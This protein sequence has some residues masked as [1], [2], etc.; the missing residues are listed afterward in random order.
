[1]VKVAI[2]ILLCGLFAFASTSG[3]LTNLNPRF[4]SKQ[5]LLQTCFMFFFFFFFINYLYIVYYYLLNVC[6]LLQVDALNRTL[7]LTT[8]GII[9]AKQ[10][11]R[12]ITRR[13]ERSATEEKSTGTVSVVR[14]T[15][16]SSVLPDDVEII[17]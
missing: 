2:F 17:T 12:S 5:T 11:R 7:S 6:N 3:T 14:T 10:A 16:Q 4:L 9:A 1:M 15:R 8:R 13:R